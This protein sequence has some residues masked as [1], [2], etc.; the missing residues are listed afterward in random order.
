MDAMR[1]A[2]PPG[3][4]TRGS[5][6]LAARRRQ[7]V[8][9]FALIFPACAANKQPAASE[10][11]PEP[12]RAAAPAAP[13]AL[14]PQTL[15]D[16]Y[17][18]VDPL[19][20]DANAQAQTS[21]CVARVIDAGLPVTSN[22]ELESL[23][24]RFRSDAAGHPASPVIAGMRTAMKLQLE[25]HPARY[26]G[27]CA[28]GGSPNPSPRADEPLYSPSNP[29]DDWARCMPLTGT[30]QE[31]AVPRCPPSPL[32]ASCVDVIRRSRADREFRAQVTLAPDGEPSAV[33][34][35]P[36]SKDSRAEERAMLCILKQLSGR[37]LLSLQRC[38]P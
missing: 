24:A 35:E 5:M 10:P 20:F 33:R 29:F 38:E 30:F 1:R 26:M 23:L 2:L 22:A 4:A 18:N 32:D 27:S 21:E 19:N 12:A 36:A 25:L 14:P 13:S 8:V 15:A 17:R 6:P 34:L 37:V 31:G 11:T 9:A 28:V 3:V 7:R 16:C